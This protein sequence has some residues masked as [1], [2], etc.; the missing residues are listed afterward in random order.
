VGGRGMRGAVDRALDCPGM[1]AP[2]PAVALAELDRRAS[3]RRALAR[4]RADFWGL[5]TGS[6]DCRTEEMTSPTQP[7]GRRW[8]SRAC[9]LLASMRLAGRGVSCRDFVA[10]AAGERLEQDKARPGFVP[11]GPRSSSGSQLRS[12]PIAFS[13]APSRRPTPGSGSPVELIAV[14][15]RPGRPL[16]RSGARTVRRIATHPRAGSRAQAAS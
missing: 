5:W 9:E 4:D 10:E 11:W 8:W 16:S 7:A 13:A 1:R 3:E 2:P 6:P 14:D 15:R 12:S